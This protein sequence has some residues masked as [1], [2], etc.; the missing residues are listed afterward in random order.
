MEIKKKKPEYTIIIFPLF[1]LYQKIHSEFVDFIS[2]TFFL[3]LWYIG[4]LFL[5][6]FKKFFLKIKFARG[7]VSVFRICSL[8][9]ISLEVCI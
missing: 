1:F 6:A 8:I 9:F 7:F 3:Y 2:R 5:F 4:Q